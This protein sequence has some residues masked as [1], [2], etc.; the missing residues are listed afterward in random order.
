MMKRKVEVGCSC[1]M[2]ETYIKIKGQ[3]RYLYRAVDRSAIRLISYYKYI[4]DF[5]AVP[6][7]RCNL[8]DEPR[9]KGFHCYRG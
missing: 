2:D 8:C 3:W 5:G 1:R 6:A 7:I 4:G 9:H